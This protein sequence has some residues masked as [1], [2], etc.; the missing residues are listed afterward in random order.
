MRICRASFVI[1]LLA[2]SS[3]L[4]AESLSLRTDRVTVYVKAGVLGFPRTPDGRPR[5][6]LVP[7]D[8]I[9][10]RNQPGLL[11]A[12]EELGWTGCEKTIAIVREGETTAVETSP[13]GLDDTTRVLHFDE[14]DTRAYTVHLCVDSLADPVIWADLARRCLMRTGVIDSVEFHARE[15]FIVAPI[16][17]VI[18]QVYPQDPALKQSGS[19]FV[20]VDITPT[21]TVS[22]AEC[23]RSDLPSEYIDAAVK[24][25]G[26]WRFRVPKGGYDGRARA[27]IVLTIP[28]GFGDKAPKQ[29]Q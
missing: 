9:D 26:Q 14:L 8:S 1:C 5:N 13:F 7:A 11:A 25:A 2:A 17:A 3:S 20:R 16:P 27:G 4:D 28:F 24:A 23:I 21:G 22:K 15:R 29:G 18:R 6:G 19:V 12:L 10:L